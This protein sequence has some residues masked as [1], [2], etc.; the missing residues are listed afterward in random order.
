[1]LGG[2]GGERVPGKRYESAATPNPSPARRGPRPRA[3]VPTAPIR[4]PGRKGAVEELVRSAEGAACARGEPRP[5]D[6][7]C[8]LRRHP[9]SLQAP[10]RSRSG[11]HPRTALRIQERAH[12][13]PLSGEQGRRE[14]ARVR[15]LPPGST[16][17]SR[18]PESRR[19]GK[20]FQWSLVHPRYRSHPDP[21]PELD[22]PS[23]LHPHPQPQ[24]ASPQAA[25]AALDTGNSWVLYS[26]SPR[27]PSSVNSACFSTKWR[28]RSR[29]HVA[30]FPLPVP[31]SP[32]A[33]RLGGG[34][35][36]APANGRTMSATAVQSPTGTR[37]FKPITH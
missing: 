2:E 16:S 25:P 7:N 14:R 8:H 32:F 29:A 12:R 31:I 27:P 3:P 37:G 19:S 17:P 30:A 35:A 1:M 15:P 36:L 6:P 9:R 18:L 4:E 10:G 33:A 26:G 5:W 21:R 20:G 28:P 11:A 34:M 22:T 23:L 24:P 13:S